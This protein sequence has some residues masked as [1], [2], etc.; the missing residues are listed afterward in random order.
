MRTPLARNE[1]C[2]P[3]APQARWGTASSPR[4]SPDPGLPGPKA[5]CANVCSQCPRSIRHRTLSGHP[6]PCSDP[7][8]KAHQGRHSPTR[9]GKVQTPAP[10]KFYH[11]FVVLGCD[12]HVVNVV[13]RRSLGVWVHPE[14]SSPVLSLENRRRRQ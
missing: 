7:W 11:Q 10:N 3:S 2:S 8:L 5:A 6:N 4:P 12:K 13:W 9:T 1:L 14:H